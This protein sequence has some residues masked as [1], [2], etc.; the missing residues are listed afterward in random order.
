MSGKR[1][2]VGPV[3][4]FFACFHPFSPFP[5]L[6]FLLPV[7]FLRWYFSKNKIIYHLLTRH[8]SDNLQ[9][10]TMTTTG[11]QT[12]FEIRLFFSEGWSRQI[13]IT[14]LSDCHRKF[15]YTLESLHHLHMKAVK[16]FVFVL[17]YLFIKSHT[18]FLMTV[19]KFSAAQH[20]P[21]TYSPSLHAYGNINWL[22]EAW[23]DP[24]IG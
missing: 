5:Y 4:L 1:R 6:H 3:L 13:T 11:S 24:P 10:D 18:H 16:L 22:P 8:C 7:P 23:Q 19:I 9:Q 21:L 12:D 14:I 17:S 15:S 20:L 2:S